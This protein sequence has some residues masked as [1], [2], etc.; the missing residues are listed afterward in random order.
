MSFSAIAP[1][2]EVD[3][4]VFFY[5]DPEIVKDKNW[6]S[7]SDITLNYTF[8]RTDNPNTNQ[9]NNPIPTYNAPNNANQSANT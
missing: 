9:L 7:I 4:P 1:H 5:I 6:R 8:F 3:M 2:E